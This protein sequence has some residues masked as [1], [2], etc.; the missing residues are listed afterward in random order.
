MSHTID[1]SERVFVRMTAF[2]AVSVNGRWGFFSKIPTSGQHAVNPN[3]SGA[4][5]KCVP[6]Q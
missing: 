1:L 3:S 2:I 5:P 6:L 4:L